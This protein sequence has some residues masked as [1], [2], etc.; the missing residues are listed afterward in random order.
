MRRR[1]TL[2]GIGLLT[3]AVWPGCWDQPKVAPEQGAIVIQPEAE[4]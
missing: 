4:K 1:P 2:V 3:L